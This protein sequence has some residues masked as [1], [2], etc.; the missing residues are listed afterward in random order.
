MSAF[1]NSAG[2][3]NQL[4]GTGLSLGSGIIG[5]AI[6]GAINN[7]Y[8]KQS[9]KRQ[10]AYNNWFTLNQDALRLRGM[11]NAGLNPALLNGAPGALSGGAA[12]SASTTISTPSADYDPAAG[13]MDANKDLADSQTFKNYMDGIR[14]SFLAPE[15]KRKLQQDI[16]TSKAQEGLFGSQQS[17]N[18]SQ[19]GLNQR[20]L[21]EIKESW[22][23]RL[24]EFM[25]NANLSEENV[26][27]RRKEN[28]YFYNTVE[29]LRSQIRHNNAMSSE[30]EQRVLNI[31]PELIKQAQ[32]ETKQQ[33]IRF[34]NENSEFSQR[35]SM[36]SW[37]RRAMYSI[38]PDLSGKV[39]FALPI[40]NSISQAV[41]AG[42]N[43]YG[44]VR[45]NSNVSFNM[46]GF[47]PS[48]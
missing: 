28:Q 36:L 39:Q 47:T 13:L 11:R 10:I 15:E 46:N 33:R 45:G 21:F 4:A 42:A 23:Y 40:I 34:G 5:G 2:F 7:A 14:T 6:Q 12:P 29:Y 27:Y 1:F 17:L 43:L 26:K 20:Q 8:S 24:R 16:A 37:T 18:E 35:F 32:N 30:I 3:G 44:S 22:P 9:F 19:T 48:W 31:L 25:A 41:N 38:D